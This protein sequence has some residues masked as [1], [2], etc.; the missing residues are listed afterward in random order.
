[1]PFS[2]RLNVD[3]PPGEDAITDHADALVVERIPLSRRVGCFQNCESLFW[4][5]MILHR[6]LAAPVRVWKGR[7]FHFFASYLEP[8]KM[9]M[10]DVSM[11]QLDCI[12]IGAIQFFAATRTTI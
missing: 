5:K 1:M 9:R 7:G 11:V 3:L 12:T 4:R 10:K 2:V 8:K 6:R